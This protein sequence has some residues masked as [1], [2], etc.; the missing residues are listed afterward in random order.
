MTKQCQMTTRIAHIKRKCYDSWYDRDDE[1]GLFRVKPDWAP[2]DRRQP[3]GLA[4]P[5]DLRV[6]ADEPELLAGP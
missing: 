5:G 6:P 2:K 1:N 3:A 4:L